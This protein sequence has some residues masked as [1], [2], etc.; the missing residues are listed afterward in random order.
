V[1]NSA[2]TEEWVSTQPGRVHSQLDLPR[3]EVDRLLQR[4]HG[5]KCWLRRSQ[6]GR[7]VYLIRA[8]QELVAPERARFEFCCV[9]VRVVREG[10]NLEPCISEPVVEALQDGPA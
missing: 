7:H 3:L 6:S 4:R 1:A 5:G 9:R 10:R 8:Y 2:C